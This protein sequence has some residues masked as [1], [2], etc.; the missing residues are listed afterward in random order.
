MASITDNRATLALLD[1]DRGGRDG[2]GVADAQCTRY[3]TAAADARKEV[4][5]DRVAVEEPLQISIL[6]RAE[7]G[8]MDER[9]FTVTMRTPG[10]DAALAIGLLHS[11]G[12]IRAAA[13][14]TTIEY[15]GSG[16]SGEY[17]ELEVTLAE[18]IIPDWS[19]YERNLTTQSSCGVCGKTS[20][21]S[22]ELKSPPE[23]DQTQAWLDSDIIRG[24]GETLRA[25]QRHFQETGGVHA[26]GLFNSDGEL[27]QVCEDVGRHNAMDKLVGTDLCIGGDEPGAGQRIVLLSGRISFELVQKAV[28]AGIPV[29]A[30][31]GAPSSLAIAVAQRFDLTLIGF[32]S[33]EGF[34]LYHGEW[35]LRR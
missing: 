24:L 18:G 4:N 7:N 2:D 22:L 34:N 9:V 25:Q 8:D 12:L 3:S 29:I 35:R 17:N 11:E 26:A 6:W 13:D 32:L 27:L 15:A 5:R 33:R 19:Q 21:Q 10:N 1:I 16:R 14:I 20:L 23:L 28:M 30:G 31:V